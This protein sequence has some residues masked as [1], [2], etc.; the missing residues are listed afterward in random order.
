MTATLCPP[1]PAIS[2][3]TILR[4]VAGEIAALL[5]NL[6]EV[7][8]ETISDLVSALRHE[9]PFFDAYKMARHLEQFH[10]WDC[11]ADTVDACETAWASVLEHHRKEVS[12]WVAANSIRPKK[13]L[14]DKVRVLTR[15]PDR[16]QQEYEGEIARI[17][18]DQAIYSVMIPKLGHVRD[19][20]GTHGTLFNFEQVEAWDHTLVDAKQPQDA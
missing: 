14:G 17:D 16:T 1:R 9:S 2:S 3:D 18:A 5:P 11:D 13:S 6:G 8:D 19:G 7:T 12:N 10:H 20:V 4:T 15:G